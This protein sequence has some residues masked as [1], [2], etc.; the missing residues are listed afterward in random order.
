MSDTESGFSEILALLKANP[1]GMSVTEIAEAVHT[2]RNTAARYLDNLLVSGR[3]EMRTFGKA[4]VFFESKRVPVSAMLNLSSEMVLLIDS[5]LKIIQVNDSL[6]SFLHAEA[7]DI[8]GT[9][10]YEGA[11]RAFCSGILTEQIRRALSGE[12]IKSELRLYVDNAEHYL[13]ERISPMVLADGRPGVTLI[14]DDITAEVQAKTALEQ[15]ESLFRRLVETVKDVLWEIDETFAIQYVSP[16]IE[17]MLGYTPEE[18]AGRSFAELMPEEA[19]LH[20]LREIGSGSAQETGFTLYDFPL[21]T[22]EGKTVYGEFC[23]TP[24]IIEGEADVFLGYSGALHD[25]TAQHSAELSARR[26]KQFLGA[27]IDNIP[28]L[29]AVVDLKDQKIVYVNERLEEEI[30]YPKEQLTLLDA[31]EFA[32]VLA[33]ASLERIFAEAKAGRFSLQTTSDVIMLME[34][35]YPCDIRTVPFTMTDEQQY[36]VVI[37]SSPAGVKR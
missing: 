24:V 19:A 31:N 25:V 15:S 20:F 27:V 11:C 5:D 8:A 3:V 33:S 10:V 7:D 23:A 26:W 1:R 30:G 4:K 32:S 17:S 18:L 37:F 16:Q 22:K 12:M 21:L 9:F 6:L 14:L 36:L 2:N 28:S 13:E 35:K 34:E 29:I